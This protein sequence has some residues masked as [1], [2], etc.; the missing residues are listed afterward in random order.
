MNQPENHFRKDG[1]GVHLLNTEKEALKKRILASPLPSKHHGVTFAYPWHFAPMRVAASALLLLFIV[2]VPVTYAAQKSGPGDFLHGFELTIVEGLEE[3]V[4]VST[5]SRLAYA[6][7]RVEERLRELQSEDTSITAAD[8]A[9]MNENLED[10]VGNVLKE[11]PQEKDTEESVNSLIRVSALL[12]AHDNA[13]DK[14]GAASSAVEDLNMTVTTQLFEEVEEY[15]DE[16]RPEV[17]AETVRQ[18]VTELDNLL[19]NSP[20]NLV[21]ADVRGHLDE[22]TEELQAGDPEDAFEEIVEAKIQL[23]TQDYG[24]DPEGN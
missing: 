16:Q 12:R 1:K 11:V 15:T 2:G 21:T 18:E 5:R 4:R 22:A 19:K 20:N 7:T 14:A 8:A 10:H 9:E 17:L 23:L 3:T 24:E 13:L 6:T